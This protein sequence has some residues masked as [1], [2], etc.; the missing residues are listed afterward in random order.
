[1]TRQ[2]G[3]PPHA[4]GGGGAGRKRKLDDDEADTY[5]PRNRRR[6]SPGP[7]HHQRQPHQLEGYPQ[8]WQTT[9]VGPQRNSLRVLPNLPFPAASTNESF[10]RAPLAP[11][12]PNPLPP[13]GSRE[14]GDIRKLSNDDIVPGMIVFIK[15][16]SNQDFTG[17]PGLVVGRQDIHG[18]WPIMGL[19]NW[20]GLSIFEKWGD[21]VASEHKARCFRRRYL[22][23]DHP[24]ARSHDDMPVLP[25]NPTGPRLP[26]QSYLDLHWVRPF[27]S[28][29]LARFMPGWAPRHIE[30]DDKRRTLETIGRMRASW[31][32]DTYPY[33][34]FDRSHLV[35]REGERRG[36]RRGERRGGRQAYRGSYRPSYRNR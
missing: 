10:P 1:M 3:L 34:Y 7:E 31:L 23:I 2:G 29:D 21:S 20:N 24:G 12:L 30:L 14:L 22:L 32:E 8:D 5:R 36:Q 27:R 17:H 4:G 9:A 26:K 6:T 35:E 11:P 19:T 18:D 13:Q 28:V 33:E 16:K 15:K 25:L